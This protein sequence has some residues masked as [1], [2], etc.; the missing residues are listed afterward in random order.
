MFSSNFIE[1]LFQLIV[2]SSLAYV[3]VKHA[4][5][6]F[7]QNR[8]ELY[9]YSKW[10]FHKNNIHFSLVLIF[11][12]IVLILNIF[13]KNKSLIL[14][15]LLTLAFSIYLIYKESQKQYIKDLVLT[16]RVKRQIV[17]MTILMIII[18]VLS[19]S[20]NS[21][22]TCLISIYIPYLLIYIMA[23]ITLPVENM[24]KKHYENE[25]RS[26]LNGMHNLLK[27]GITGSYGKTST[28][29]IVSDIISENRYTLITPSSYNT[30]MGITRTIRE[31]LKPIHEVFVCE[32]GADKVG[33][34]SYLMDFVKPKYGVVTSI[35][36]QHLNTF[37]NLDNIIKEKMQ[38]IEMLPSDGVGFINLDNEYIRNYQ[39]R[40][41][42]K[43]VSVGIDNKDADY[44]AENI[45]YSKDGSKFSVNINNRNY[46]FSTILLGK[47]NITN[48][49]I[50]IAIAIEMGIDI[51]TIVKNVMSVKQVEHRLQVKKVNNYTFID[52]AFN[53]NPVGSKM[54]LDVLAL[55]PGKR[56]VV[57]PGMIDLGL[58]QDK[59]NYEYGKY[60][61]DKA[62]Y[63]LLIGEKQTMAIRNGLENIG[64]D[65]NNVLTFK[66]VN[67]AFVY[68]YQ[69]FSIQDTILLEND[70][71]DAFNV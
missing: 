37:H 54:A 25:A 36:P 39:I 3:F 21:F 63:V 38:E 14:V 48:I 13:L 17:V 20:F 29:N 15:L 35:G 66:T 33:E 65:M 52:D 44:V 2:Y 34:I 24:I 43:I 40:N 49:L 1:I 26:I 56:V 58:I 61:L 50:G 70:L 62:D 68:I 6:M 18:I 42:C 4:L 8:Y 9:R 10:L 32:M 31:L 71:P 11:L 51:K 16:A 5:Q 46:K 69:N 7:Q 23:I 22:F 28:K 57:T 45:K 12:L 30:P 19:L 55:M 64:F 67:E 60:M 27:I 59:T 53:S 41:T 47:H